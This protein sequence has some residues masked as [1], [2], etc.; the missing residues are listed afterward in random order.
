MIRKGNVSHQMKSGWR[1]FWIIASIIVMAVIFIFS[2]Q[3]SGKSEDLSD[4]VAG[5]LRMKQKEVATRVSNQKVFL[6]LTL[7]KLAHIILFAG[8]GFCL[9]NAFAGIRGKFF[10]VIGLGYLYAVADELH[11]TLS[12]RYGRWEDTLIDLLGIIIGIAAAMILTAIWRRIQRNGQ[13]GN[14]Y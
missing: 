14:T 8:L 2:S 11:Q 12:G 1:V 13:T 9:T 6:G 10:W 5:A 7:R 4:A 3:N